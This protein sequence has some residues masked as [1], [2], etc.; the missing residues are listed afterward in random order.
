MKTLCNILGCLFGYSFLALTIVITVD[1]IFR[2]LRLFSIIGTGEVSAY[3][4]AVCAGFSFTIAIVNRTHIRI[5]LL[6]GRFSGKSRAILNW[7]AMLL[8]AISAIVIVYSSYITL[9][10]TIYYK[11]KSTVLAISLQF[12]QI[13]WVISLAIFCI[14]TLILFS[15]ASYYLFKKDI[16]NLNKHFHPKA[17]KEELEEE[18]EDITRRKD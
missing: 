15:Q 2:S 3:I 17:A 7:F 11:S 14:V 6:I 16:D 18:L 10:E 4:M 8:F 9:T 5:D 13:L 12:P 1:T